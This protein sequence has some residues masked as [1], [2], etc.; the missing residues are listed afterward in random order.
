MQML[1]GGVFNIINVWKDQE[2]MPPKIEWESE[3]GK[4]YEQ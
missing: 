2:W 4:M 3:G 1:T